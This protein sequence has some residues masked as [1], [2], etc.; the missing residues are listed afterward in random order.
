MAPKRVFLSLSSPLSL[1]P[2]DTLLANSIP[3]SLLFSLASDRLQGMSPV[4]VSNSLSV[5]CYSHDEPLPVVV[6]LVILL[7]SEGSLAG[8]VA[9]LLSSSL[10]SSPR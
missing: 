7:H 4:P 1:S 6:A 5:C 8:R 3:H 9:P 10:L 2:L